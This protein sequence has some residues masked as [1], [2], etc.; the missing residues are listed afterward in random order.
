MKPGTLFHISEEGNIQRFIPKPS[1]SHYDQITRDVVFAITGELLHNYLLPRDCPRVTFYAGKNTSSADKERFLSS[2]DANYIIAV[3]QKWLPAIQHIKLYCYEFPAETFSLLDEC[4]GYYVSYQQVIPTTV[5]LIDN[6]LD[7]LFKRNIELRL[8]P[9][10][11][12]LANEVAKSTLNF[13]IIRLRNAA[14]KLQ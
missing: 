6:T 5:K 14:P 4:A 7:E 1:P 8:L 10:L 2:S 3:E 11:H 13:S 9:N 12:H